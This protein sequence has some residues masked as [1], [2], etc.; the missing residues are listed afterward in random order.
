MDAPTDVLVRARPGIELR[1]DGDALPTLVGHFA[2]FDRW[3][4]IDSWYEGRFM[5]RVAPGA[6]ADTF[7][8][9]AGTVKVLF[10]HGH[11]P[12]LGNKPLGPIDKLREDKTGAYYEVPLIDTDYNR[13]FIV[14]AVEASLL[15]ASFRFE[16]TGESW[17][18]EPDPSDSNP[19]GLP[20][21]TIQKV[22][23]YE[24]GPVT[25][26]AYPDG[27]TVGM[28]S[29]TDHYIAEAFRLDDADPAL[30][31]AVE[32]YPILR[33]LSMRL[34]AQGGA[35]E[36]G[37]GA[38]AVEEPSVADSDRGDGGSTRTPASA[39]VRAR[40]ARKGID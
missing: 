35:A 2:V 30:T 4:L 9:D 31:R 11:D 33:S 3:T 38:V 29:M 27:T 24:F 10:D 40:L 5:E 1:A 26:P 20:E 17:D 28:R 34:G 18:D 15:G 25:F 14:P 13:D 7:R 6:F 32:R 23:L 39:L 36:R 19:K 16:V 12:T 21:R 22:R 8:E 37:D